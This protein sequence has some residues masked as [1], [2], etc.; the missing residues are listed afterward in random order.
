MKCHKC[1]KTE[2]VKSMTIDNSGRF[3]EPTSY[4]TELDVSFDVDFD[5]AP[6]KTVRLCETC[7]SD[8]A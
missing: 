4:T 7:Y 5:G 6:A 8:E 1:G 2:G 3:E